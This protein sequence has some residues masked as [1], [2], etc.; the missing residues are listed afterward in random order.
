MPTRPFRLFISSTTADLHHCRTTAARILKERGV[1]VIVEEEFATLDYVAINRHLWEFIQ[2]SDAVLFIVGTRYGSEPT[3][4]PPGVPRHSYAQIEWEFARQL[5]KARYV[6][7]TAPAF[8]AGGAHLLPESEDRQRLQ[9]RHRMEVAGAKVDALHHGFADLAQFEELIQRIDFP[10]QVPQRPRKVVALP[11]GTLGPLFKGRDS[12]MESLHSHLHTQG[13]LTALVG[14]HTLYG[15]GGI[16]KTRLAVEYALAHGDEYQAVL[17]VTA[18][19]PSSL[20]AGLSQLAH[21]RALALSPPSEWDEARQREA[22]VHWLEREPG[23]LLILDNVDSEEAA[24]AVRALLP[25]LSQGHVII[26]SRLAGWEEG[27]QALEL[28]PLALEAATAFLL[29]KCSTRKHEP[30]QD[31]PNASTLAQ[32]LGTL[33]LALEQAGAY[34]NVQGLTFHE[35]LE[36][37]RRQDG[38]VQKWFN[39]DLMR[40]PRSVMTTWATSFEKLSEGARSLLKMLCWFAPDPAPRRIFIG[41][42]MTRILADRLNVGHTAPTLAV[43]ELRHY[44]LLRITG[45]DMV[46]VHLL[47]QEVTRHHLPEPGDRHPFITDCLEAVGGFATGNPHEPRAWPVWEPLRPHILALAHWAE[48]L[49]IPRPTAWL[50]SQLGVLLMRKAAYLEA[51]ACMQRALRLYD[52]SSPPLHEQIASLESNLGTVAERLD[53]PDIALAHYQRALSMVTGIDATSLSLA[54]TLHN[55][56]AALYVDRHKYVEA[57]HHLTL[58]RE[59]EDQLPP[60]GNLDPQPGSTRSNQGVLLWRMG[61]YEEAITAYGEALAIIEAHPNRGPNHP[62][63]S[64]MRSNLGLSLQELGRF[65]EAEA[66]FRAAL[67]ADQAV[68]GLKHPAVGRDLNNLA[69]LLRMRGDL[70]SAES[71][72]RESLGN[73]EETYS[74]AHSEVADG[75]ANLG[76]VL[77]DLHRLEEAEEHLRKA[78]QLDEA[79]RGGDHLRIAATCL[80]LALVA[81]EQGNLAEALRLNSRALQ[82]QTDTLGPEHPDLATTWNNISRVFQED[83]DKGTARLAMRRAMAIDRKALGHRHHRLGTRLGNLAQI[84]WQMGRLRRAGHLYRAAITADQATLG[85]SHPAIAVDLYNLSEL[86]RAQGREEEANARLQE[87]ADAA[88][89]HAGADGAVADPRL[90]MILEKAS[91]AKEA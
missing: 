43:T 51:Q 19:T 46:Q 73:D 65:E 6:F 31:E 55:N 75:H 13:N 79:L 2:I 20:D 16:G 35:Y 83:G 80:N 4:L 88:R 5:S 26:T 7:V 25:R 68:F 23:W 11:Y 17:F 60:A 10:T 54:A 34:I 48:L 22:V 3:N 56:L 70:A 90:R 21:P 76:L 29:E 38:L 42:T 50:L 49:D 33:P 45:E 58:V 67:Q 14:S 52:R 47:V 36:L 89:A 64:I 30:G 40:Y 85:D 82:L 8:E 87:A 15:L 84:Y 28:H 91:R 12:A 9:A 78:L 53:A 77:L 74:Q 44:S 71:L 63:A 37:W 81:R 66:C 32:V 61:R 86:L 59:L 24:T 72:L 39:E 62:E 1:E 18:D 41:E 27:V 57:Q 69:L